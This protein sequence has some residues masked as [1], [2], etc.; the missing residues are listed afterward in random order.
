MAVLYVKLSP[1]DERRLAELAEQQ[2]TKD[3]A[4]E[5]SALRMY[6]SETVRRLIR[7]AHQTLGRKV[8]NGKRNGPRPA[9]T[10]KRSA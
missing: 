5:G 9:G 1:E 7:E 2:R 3:G 10:S 8:S 6:R 4:D